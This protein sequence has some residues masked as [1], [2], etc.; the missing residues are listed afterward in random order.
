MNTVIWKNDFKDFK[1]LYETT[2]YFRGNI[3]EKRNNFL[4]IKEVNPYDEEKMEY[5]YN[6]SEVTYGDFISFLRDNYNDFTEEEKNAISSILKRIDNLEISIDVVLKHLL[7][8]LVYPSQHYMRR[9]II[10]NLC[11]V[12][13]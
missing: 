1:G 6:H 4:L 2:F 10:E 13:S 8:A 11:S 3:I 9:K 5:F 7:N 12:I